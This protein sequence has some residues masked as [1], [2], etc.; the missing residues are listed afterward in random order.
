MN[1]I[2]ALPGCFSG[3]RQLGQTIVV[4]I[5]SMSSHLSCPMSIVIGCKVVT[6][7]V[8]KQTNKQKGEL[9]HQQYTIH[10]K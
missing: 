4:T 6:E 1:N 8:R 10:Y 7:C 5:F 9:C 3:S 2:K